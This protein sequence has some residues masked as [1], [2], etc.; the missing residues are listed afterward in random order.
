MNE[1]TR[2]TEPKLWIDLPEETFGIVQGCA[3]NVG[4]VRALLTE[5]DSILGVLVVEREG[6][7]VPHMALLHSSD[8]LV[9]GEAVVEMAKAIKPSFWYGRKHPI[10]KCQAIVFCSQEGGQTAFWR[11]A[12]HTF[13]GEHVERLRTVVGSLSRK[14]PFRLGIDLAT[15]VFTTAQTLRPDALI[16]YGAKDLHRIATT[17]VKHGGEIRK[18]TKNRARAAHIAL[19]DVDANRLNLTGEDYVRRPI[20]VFDLRGNKLKGF[21][22]A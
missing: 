21:Q 7:P 22:V 18:L 20:L 2:I 10:T 1:P 3:H 15:G 11:A 14:K 12:C 19:G 16:E 8:P 13:C 17:Q 4:T 9:V 5:P 6:E